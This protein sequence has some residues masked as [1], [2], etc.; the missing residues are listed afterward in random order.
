[1]LLRPPVT[2]VKVN[3]EAYDPSP[4]IS[5]KWLEGEPSD[6]TPSCKSAAIR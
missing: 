2:T 6:P 3:I 5:S 4:I 1:M